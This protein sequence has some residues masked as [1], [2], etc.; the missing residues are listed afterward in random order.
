MLAKLSYVAFGFLAAVGF[1][2]IGA[3]IDAPST[4]PGKTGRLTGTVAP[5]GILA[6]RFG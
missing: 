5:A 2:V 4:G 1:I 3:L 6:E